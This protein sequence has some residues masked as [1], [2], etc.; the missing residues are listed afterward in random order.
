MTD[1]VKR[2]DAAVIPASVAA[3]LFLFCL[4]YRTVNVK[5]ISM[6]YHSPPFNNDDLF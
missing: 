6:L 1:N 3:V 4:R 5:I 2:A